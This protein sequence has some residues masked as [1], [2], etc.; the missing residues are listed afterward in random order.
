MT[1]RPRLRHIRLLLVYSPDSEERPGRH[2]R[3]IA[4]ATLALTAAIVVFPFQSAVAL[5]TGGEGNRPLADPG[6]PKGAAELFNNPARIA[7]WEGPPFGG[8][9]WHAECRGD[10]KAFSEVLAGF[11]RLGVKNKRVVVHDGV[12]QS[13]WLNPNREPAKQAAA[14]MDWIFMAWQSAN[15]EQLRKMPA[16][17]NPTDPR[18]AEGGPPSQLDV[19]TGGNLRWSDVTVPAEIE[20]IDNRLEAHGFTTADGIVIEGKVIDLATKQPVTARASLQRVEPQQTGGYHYPVVVETAAGPQGRWVLKKVRAG[21]YRVV[22]DAEEFVPRVVG[23]AQF[24]DQPG[25]YSY[26]SGLS[27]QAPVSGRIT[28]ESGQPLSDVEVRLQDVVADVGGRYESP[29]DYSAKTDAD[30]R[31]RTDHVPVGRAT[32]WIH[33]PGYCRPGLGQPIKT[34]AQDVALAM[35]RSAGVRVTV[36]FAGMPRP[37]A[38]IVQMEPEGGAAVG[39]WSG[40]GNIDARNQIAFN[41]VPPGRYIVQGR[42]NPSSANQ[43]SKPITVDLKGGQTSEIALPAN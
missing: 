31:F 7:W 30:G 14:R 36:D 4:G 33:K 22:I 39:K 40:S 8:G 38:Y 13:F 32:I 29:N 11:A 42:P 34:P 6:W 27:R 21:W 23:Y 12:G 1:G 5:I 16:D 35:L 9:Q 10:A 17:L 25:W 24:D 37:A 15:W 43:Q 41:D 26:D 3:R 2:R 19:Y 18:D 28:D 20:L